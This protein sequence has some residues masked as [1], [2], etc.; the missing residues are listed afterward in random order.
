M[1]K[2]T[3]EIEGEI[4]PEQEID[5]CTMGMFIVGESCAYPLLGGH[6]RTPE[7]YC[8]CCANFACKMRARVSG[9]VVPNTEYAYSERR[10]LSCFEFTW[11]LGA[12]SQVEV[13]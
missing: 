6:P 13:R 11:C 3:G 1:A 2:D 5:F 12:L 7:C 4:A 8:C 9:S 10:V